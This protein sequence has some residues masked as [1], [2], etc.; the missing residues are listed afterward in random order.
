MLSKVNLATAVS[1][2]KCLFGAPVKM[3]MFEAGRL[4]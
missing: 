1:L 2:V 3:K 4:L